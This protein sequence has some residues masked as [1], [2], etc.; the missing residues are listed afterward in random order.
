MWFN[1]KDPDEI[2]P[3][4]DEYQRKYQAFDG[5]VDKYLIYHCEDENAKIRIYIDP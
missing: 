5:I 2:Y 3:P 1:K 4:K